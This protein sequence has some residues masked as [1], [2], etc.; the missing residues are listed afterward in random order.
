LNGTLTLSTNLSVV[1]ANTFYR[2][3]G[4]TGS[5][6]LSNV[7]TIGER[8]FRE[9]SSLTGSLDLSNVQTIGVDAFR[10]CSSLTGSLDL[11]NVQTIGADVFR[12][13]S[14]L[15][16][17]L[18]LSTNLSVVN[19]YTFYECS[20][21]TGS[22]DL[23][24]VQ[25]IG[26][27][28]FKSCS[29]LNGTLTLSTNLSVI[30][31]NTFEDCTGLTSVEFPTSLTYIGAR[32]FR[33]CTVTKYD[34]SLN[35]QL[36]FDASTFESTTVVNVY[37]YPGTTF[38]EPRGNVKYYTLEREDVSYAINDTF[39]I[40]M[41]GT[42]T[43]TQPVTY[44][45]THPAIASVDE[46]GL[47]TV[48][49]SGE[50]VTLTA[51]QEP[52]TVNGKIVETSLTVNGTVNGNTYILNPDDTYSLSQYNETDTVFII[53]DTYL[54]KP[55][56]AI[57]P[58]AFKGKGMTRITFPEGLLSIGES[59]FE[60]NQLSGPF[61]LPPVK[62]IGTKAFKNAGQFSTQFILPV[63]T[64]GINAFEGCGFTITI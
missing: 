64:V 32:A 35:T 41:V 23:S 59:A 9:C 37:C 33:G 34:L 3:S 18:T 24:N 11:S 26:E 7:Q 45:S 17:T 46:T 10:E 38:P 51:K 27:G 49:A 13:C 52:S 19:A 28:A 47:V 8:A 39:P 60:D 56:T 4:L 29:G 40:T 6:D 48:L 15:N 1:N 58:N 25:T 62:F 16:G 21:L 12:H 61:L 44:S 36:S 57:G 53:P 55:V 31:A 42:P 43:N 63:A 54:D 5:L 22:L 50:E 30:N 14:G 20:S 2:C